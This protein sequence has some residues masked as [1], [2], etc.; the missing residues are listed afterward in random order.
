M[1]KKLYYSLHNQ[2]GE[3][4]IME[5]SGCMEWIKGDLESNYPNSE[6]LSEED[7]PHYTLTP[8][9]MTDQEYEALPDQ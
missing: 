4:G 8:V 5:L 3:G 1:E 7:L 6:T 9:W 2:D